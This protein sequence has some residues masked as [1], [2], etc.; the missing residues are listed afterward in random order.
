MD[1]QTFKVSVGNYLGQNFGR[2]TK[3]LETAITLREVVQDAAGEWIERTSTS[4]PGEGTMKNTAAMHQENKPMGVGVD[5]LLCLVAAS[6]QA[7]WAQNQVQS[8]NSTQ[9]AG[10]GGGAHR[11]ERA[12]GRSA[13]GFTVQTPPRIA[14]DL[15]G[16][17]NGMAATSS[18]STKATCGPPRRAVRRARAPGAESAASLRL[19]RGARRANGA[20]VGQVVAPRWAAVQPGGAGALCAADEQRAAVALTDMDFAGP[21]GAGR[22]VVNLPSNQSALT[23][24]SKGRARGGVPAVALAETCAALDV[25]DFGT[26]VQL[27]TTTQV[28]D[29]VRMVVDPARQLGAQRPTRATTSSCWK[30]A[31]K[32]RPEQAHA[33][34]G[35]AGDKLSLNFQNIEVRALLQVIA[36]FTNFNVVTSDTVTG[37][38]TCG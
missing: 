29:K 8:I 27:I 38:V 35:Y 6:A 11:T 28:G 19:P 25:T 32:G 3:I 21:D 34:P 4:N 36:D 31:R 18:R 23:S 2:I 17:V 1:N 9:Q 5:G 26:P 37:S 20:G 30:C 13:A 33:R 24:S 10:A 22:V 7:V 14:I 15:P 16:V 12:A